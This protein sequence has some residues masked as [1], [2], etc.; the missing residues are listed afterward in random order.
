MGKV[1]EDWGVEMHR[2]KQ[3]ETL[4]GYRLRL[5]F[6][7]GTQGIVDLSD[8]V[9]RGVF[10]F[11]NDYGLFQKVCI[12]DTGELVWPNAVDLCPDSLYLRLTGKKPGEIFPALLREPVDA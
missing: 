6:E 11:W 5:V 1:L 8:L 10:A 7:D 3:V 4:E 2:I 9:G 12:G